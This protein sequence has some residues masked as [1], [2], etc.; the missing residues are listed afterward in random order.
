[1]GHGR[2]LSSEEKSTVLALSEV[3]LSQRA[4]AAQVSRSKTAVLNV[5][6]RVTEKVTTKTAGRPS[7]LSPTTERMIVRT[8]LKERLS[9]AQIVTRLGLSV[10]VCTVQ[11]VLQKA[12]YTEYRHMKSRPFLTFEHHRAH[13]KWAREMM[14][15]D[16][17]FWRHV[18]FTDEKRWCF[19]GPDGLA[20][21]WAD[22]RLEPHL[23]SRRARGGGGLMIWAV[24]RGAARLRS[25]LSTAR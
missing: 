14:T 23:F 2:A 19:N 9:A 16:A 17:D 10:S 21:H 4:I 13:E 20:Y 22:K 7:S 3:K 5:I 25:P 1:M 8:A 24:C 11:R 12:Q 18:T 15:R 6:K